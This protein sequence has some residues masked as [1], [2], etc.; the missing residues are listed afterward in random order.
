MNPLLTFSML[1]V[2]IALMLLVAIVG[3]DD[4]P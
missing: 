1:A 4:E 2:L 3:A